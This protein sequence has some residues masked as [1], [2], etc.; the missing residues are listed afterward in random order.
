L[1]IEVVHKPQDQYHPIN[2]ETNDNGLELDIVGLAAENEI[3]GY[4]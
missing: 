1:Y 3:Q 2:D 4:T